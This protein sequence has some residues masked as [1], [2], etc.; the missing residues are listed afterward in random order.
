VAKFVNHPTL[1]RPCSEESKIKSRKTQGH[2]IKVRNII[3]NCEITFD[4]LT[5]AYKQLKISVKT[6]KKYLDTNQS[7]KNFL[8]FSK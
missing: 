3:T 8:F 6:I 7:Y 4:S 1:G 5:F 2:P